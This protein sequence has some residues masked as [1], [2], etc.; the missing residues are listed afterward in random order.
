ML[1]EGCDGGMNGDG[2]REEFSMGGRCCSGGALQVNSGLV[3]VVRRHL[4]G[5]GGAVGLAS[6]LNR[7]A[8]AA[9]L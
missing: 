1:T 6:N 2:G 3:V 4:G 5:R 8:L 7:T 9:R